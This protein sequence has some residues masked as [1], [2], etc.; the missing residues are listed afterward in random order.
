MIGVVYVKTPACNGCLQI[1]IVDKEIS[2]LK[3]TDDRE[4]ILSQTVVHH[5]HLRIVYFDLK[6]KYLGDMVV[7]GEN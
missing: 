5:D 1:D 3:L 7:Y 6:G 4:S 2:N